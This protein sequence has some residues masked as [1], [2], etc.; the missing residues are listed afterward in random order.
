M[1]ASHMKTRYKILQRRWS[2]QLEYEKNLNWNS[3]RCLNWKS[4]TSFADFIENL[5]DETLHACVFL[6][7]ASNDSS[8]FSIIT[9]IMFFISS[10]LFV[11]D[12]DD[13]SRCWSFYFLLATVQSFHG[14]MIFFFH[15]FPWKPFVKFF[16]FSL[17]KSF[18][19]LAII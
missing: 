9:I 19:L 6:Q 14:E 4:S 7:F 13:V 18:S 10:S 5:C 17:Y 1:R 2:K 16:F 12:Q 8:L 3:E 11:D 15:F